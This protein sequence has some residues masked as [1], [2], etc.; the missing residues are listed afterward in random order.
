MQ[1]KRKSSPRKKEK[2]K[3]EKREKSLQEPDSGS[4]ILCADLEGASVTEYLINSEE[5][6]SNSSKEEKKPHKKRTKGPDYYLAKRMKL[7]IEIINPPV[8]GRGRRCLVLDIDYTIF[9]HKSNFEKAPE[10]TRPYL[11]EFLTVCNQ[12]YDLIIWSATAMSHITTKLQNMGVLSHPSYSLT[13]V[14]TKDHMIPYPLPQKIGATKTKYQDIKPLQ[15]IWDK[16]PECYTPQNSIH[17]DDIMENFAM[18]PTNGLQISP[19]RDAPSNKAKDRE[20]WYLTQ[21]L[22]LLKDVEDV[23]DFEHKRW[24]DHIIQ[25]LWESQT[26]FAMPQFS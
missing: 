19:F 6:G 5:N 16:F 4:I 21:Y 15:I 17:I 8:A 20:L 25:K 12:H 2:E 14:L 7:N 24:K 11:H 26:M 22:L 13:M 9:D 23:R 18:N 10:Y 1:L 3:H